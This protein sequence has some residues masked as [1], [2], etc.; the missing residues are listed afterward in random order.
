MITQTRE[1]NRGESYEIGDEVVPNSLS[2]CIP[3]IVVDNSADRIVL[4]NFGLRATKGRALYQMYDCRDGEGRP[5]YLGTGIVYESEEFFQ[6]AQK[7]SQ[8]PMKKVGGTN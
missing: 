3:W 7:H 2:W 5:K 1:L 8:T 6:T 4:V